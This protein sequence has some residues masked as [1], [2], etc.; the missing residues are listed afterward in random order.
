MCD[1]SGQNRKPIRIGVR[2]LLSHDGYWAGVGAVLLL[3]RAIGGGMFTCA[4]RIFTSAAGA[5]MQPL[6]TGK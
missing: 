1:I 3:L 4:V 6:P 2:R 5:M